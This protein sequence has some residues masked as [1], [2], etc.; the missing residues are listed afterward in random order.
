MA[1]RR[2]PPPPRESEAAI[3]LSRRGTFFMNVGKFK[4]RLASGWHRRAGL[5]LKILL[6]V[7]GLGGVAAT[8][9][10]LWR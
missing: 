1:R 4:L 5:V 6:L 2:K 7:A 9:H 8:I 3:R 10:R